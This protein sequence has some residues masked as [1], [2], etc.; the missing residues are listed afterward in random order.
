MFTKTPSR[1]V[2]RGFI[3]TGSSQS[4]MQDFLERIIAQGKALG[5]EFLT[6]APELT[7]LK[8]RLCQGRFQ[9]AVLRQFKHRNGGRYYDR[10]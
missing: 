6:H 9:L 1:A 2:T 8:D 7:D 10:A 3:M 5:E 4:D